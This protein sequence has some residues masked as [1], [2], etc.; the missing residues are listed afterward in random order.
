[1]MNID[2]NIIIKCN[3]YI[4][5]GSDKTKEIIKMIEKIKKANQKEKLFN[6]DAEMILEKYLI[7]LNLLKN[8][9][10]DINTKLNKA[11]NS[12]IKNT[13]NGGV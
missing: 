4:D 6:K 11:I 10:I 12:S 9:L 8:N 5:N 1:M 3:D 13:S 2:Y 7:D